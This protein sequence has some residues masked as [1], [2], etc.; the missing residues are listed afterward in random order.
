MKNTTKRVSSEALAHMLAVTAMLVI[1]SIL[2]YGNGE[3][4]HA[5]AARS[6]TVGVASQG[7]VRDG[8]A[9]GATYVDVQ[10]ASF[11]K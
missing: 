9:S 10:R 1:A 11:S 6:E 3:T 8:A 5:S 2:F 7:P 4:R